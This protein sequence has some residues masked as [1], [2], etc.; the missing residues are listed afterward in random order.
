MKILV[1]NLSRKTTEEELRVLFEAYGEVAALN[2]VYDK[3]TGL[4]KGFGF[5]EIYD[6]R[7]ALTAIKKLNN[8]NVGGNR[9][10]VK[11]ADEKG[12]GGSR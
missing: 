5:V 2:L 11:A 4:S 1:R 7:Q 6:S 8:E 10:R 12:K 3:E 9:I